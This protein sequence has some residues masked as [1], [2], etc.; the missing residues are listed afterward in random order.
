MMLSNKL[1]S[2]K[3]KI[4]SLYVFVVGHWDFVHFKFGNVKIT[5]YLWR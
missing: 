5:T 4:D 3:N 2:L 1:I